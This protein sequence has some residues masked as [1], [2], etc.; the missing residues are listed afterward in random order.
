M[1]KGASN[2]TFSYSQLGYMGSFVIL[3]LSFF[4]TLSLYYSSVSVTHTLDL[5]LFVYLPVHS[6]SHG[7]TVLPFVDTAQGKVR[8]VWF[9]AT[10]LPVNA[11]MAE[12]LPHDNEIVYRYE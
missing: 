6:S 1:R 7:L 9:D 4:Q 12:S 5:F 3:F 10:D 11:N 2:Q 8:S